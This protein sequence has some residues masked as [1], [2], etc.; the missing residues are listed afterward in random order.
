M[1]ASAVSVQEVR[2]TPGTRP[3][4]AITSPPPGATYLIDPT[5]RREFQTL[6]LRA[7]GERGRRLDWW[8]DGRR[9]GSSRPGSA[10]EWPLAPGT[11]VMSVRDEQGHVARTSVVVR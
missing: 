1:K 3:P 7:V 4:L 6:P 2:I 8:I 9:F 5:L 10:L 11:H